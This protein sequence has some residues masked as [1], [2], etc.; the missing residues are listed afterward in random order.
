MHGGGV[1]IALFPRVCSCK[2]RCDLESFIECVWVVDDAVTSL[3]ADVLNAMDQAVP[4]GFIR[5]S[6][7]PH[8]FSSS[9]RYY[10]WKND[11]YYRR[12][13]KKNFNYFYNKFSF[14]RKLVEAT[15]K[16]DRLRWLKSID[17]NLKLQPKQFW[18]Y[19]ASYR[20]R[21]STS[22][23]L[24]VDGTH[25][26]EPCNVADAFAKYFQS[27]YNTPCTGVFPSLLQ[28]SEFLSLA[29][30]SEL[31]ICKALRRLRPSKSV[32]LDD[33]PSFVIKVCSEIFV[34]VLK[35]IFNIS[36][37]QHYFPT[38]WK[39]A[40]VV[41]VFKKSNTASVSNYRPISVLNTFFKVF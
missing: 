26:A 23:Q 14:Y 18:K 40:A 8:C 7:F 39:Q 17:D 34:P 41:P 13:K 22:V 12:F 29:P 16:S 27:V 9:L 5:K 21:N 6:K 37:T 20:K 38:V 15:I 1:L 33:I 32:G 25:L 35:H 28:S 19:V 36:L 10:I 31:D 2:R 3:N 30:I 24:E 4:R 11:Y